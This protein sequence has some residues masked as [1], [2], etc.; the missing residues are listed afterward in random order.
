MSLSRLV[1]VSVYIPTALALVN[2]EI[3]LPNGP[4]VEMA[5][6]FTL[7]KSGN[8]A[9]PAITIV[10]PTRTITLFDFNIV[11]NIKFGKKATS[12]RKKAIADKECVKPMNPFSSFNFNSNFVFM[13]QSFFIFLY[14]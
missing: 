7:S 1:F 14:H 10:A 12:N 13:L 8:N 6:L 3:N 9:A 4:N 2:L 5:V 11:L